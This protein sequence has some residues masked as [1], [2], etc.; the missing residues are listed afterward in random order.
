MEYGVKDKPPSPT[1]VIDDGQTANL[2]DLIP[3]TDYTIRVRVVTN[4]LPD[5]GVWSTPVSVTTADQGRCN[6]YTLLLKSNGC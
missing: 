6:M 3:N 4:A 1:V 5:Q 2:T